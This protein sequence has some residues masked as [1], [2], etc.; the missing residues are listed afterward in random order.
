MIREVPSKA[1]VEKMQLGIEENFKMNPPKQIKSCVY[2]SFFFIDL[3]EIH[4]SLAYEY[5]LL[6]YAIQTLLVFLDFT[7]V[8]HIKYLAFQNSVLRKSYGR[9]SIDDELYEG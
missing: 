7:Q 1:K 2:Y 5:I 8:L 3:K 6:Q 9:I 4:K